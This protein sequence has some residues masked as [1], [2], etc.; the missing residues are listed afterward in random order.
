[1]SKFRKKPVVIEA[2]QWFKNGDHPQDD[3]M[4]PFEDTGEIPKEPREGKIVRYFRHPYISGESKCI[5]CHT[6][7]H[8]HGWIDTLEGGH[9]VC[10]GDW[11]ITGVVGEYYPCKPY[12]FENTY[13][14][15]VNKEKS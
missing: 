2:T 6:K 3:T 11:I 9:D 12:V 8:D 7:Y 15:V 5:Q 4:R 1:M 13:E 14:A 10:P